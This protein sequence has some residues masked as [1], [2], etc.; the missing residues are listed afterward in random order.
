[1]FGGRPIATYYVSL[2]LLVAMYLG[3]AYLMRSLFGRVLEGI[4]VNERRMAALGFNTYRYKLA[5]F[6]I[7][8]LL[9]IW[10]SEPAVS[11]ENPSNWCREDVSVS[12]KAS[13]LRTLRRSLARATAT[14][15]HP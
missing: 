3:L 11:E 5:A 8:G 6:V 14:A 7:A 1:M 13:R 12:T 9:A 15:A 10:V 2:G 4:R